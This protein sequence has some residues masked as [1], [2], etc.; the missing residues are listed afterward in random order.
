MI[1]MPSEQGR[2]WTMF[3]YGSSNNCGSGEGVILKNNSG[4]MIEV[5]LC[6]EFLTTKNHV[7]YEAVIEGIT[8]AEEVGA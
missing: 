6:F 8:L 5:S 3:T 2:T 7:E 4:L 1:G